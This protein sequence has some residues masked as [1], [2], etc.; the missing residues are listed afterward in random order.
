[1]ANRTQILKLEMLTQT[2]ALWEVYKK[3]E[4][5][6]ENFMKVVLACVE[7][8]KHYED[9][10]A[11]LVSLFFELK[12]WL[13][14]SIEFPSSETSSL[15]QLYRLLIRKN[16]VEAKEI[17]KI[18][19]TIIKVLILSF[20]DKNSKIALDLNTY[21]IELYETLALSADI[22]LKFFNAGYFEFNVHK[23][24]I[25]LCL[26]VSAS[27]S[28]S[29]Y[30]KFFDML[31]RAFTENRQKGLLEVLFLRQTIPQIASTLRGSVK[32]A[33]KTEDD[34]RE[35]LLAQVLKILVIFIQDFKRILNL[36]VL[37]LTSICKF[38]I[39]SGF[40]E[41]PRFVSAV[42]DAM[43]SRIS[44]TDPQDQLNLQ[45][46]LHSLS[47]LLI[48]GL[49]EK[50]FKYYFPFLKGFVWNSLHMCKNFSAEVKK[51]VLNSPSAAQKLQV[52]DVISPLFNCS[53]S[54]IELKL[55]LKFASISG[56]N[57]S[58]ILGLIYQS[59][60]LS[61]DPVSYF[62]CNGERFLK[63][64]LN[65]DFGPSKEMTLLTRFYLDSIEKTEKVFI[66]HVNKDVKLTL[67]VTKLSVSMEMMKKSRKILFD[68]RMQVKE[69]QWNT[70]AISFNMK[71]K[72][73]KKKYRI[74]LMINHKRQEILNEVIK[75]FK[76]LNSLEI[77]LKGKVEYFKFYSSDLNLLSIENPD[78]FSTLQ[79]M[80]FEKAS[81]YM[82]SNFFQLTTTNSKENYPNQTVY[83]EYQQNLVQNFSI[84]DSIWSIGGLKRLI[85]LLAASEKSEDFIIFF[86]I[87]TKACSCKNFRLV[88]DDEFFSVLRLV[89]V[90][91]AEFMHVGWLEAVEDFLNVAKH[92]DIYWCAF[93]N[94]F[95]CSEIWKNLSCDF[96]IYYVETIK[97]YIFNT[98]LL[99]KP[100][101]KERINGFF[102][103]LFEFCDKTCK[104]LVESYFIQIFPECEVPK[105]IEVQLLE[106]KSS[107][108]LALLKKLVN[109]HNQIF[110]NQWKVEG[111]YHLKS[112]FD[113][114]GRR[115]YLKRKLCTAP[116]SETHENFLRRTGLFSKIFQ[117]EESI[118]SD[119]I[120]DSAT[121]LSDYSTEQPQSVEEYQIEAE[122]NFTDYDIQATGWECEIIKIK[123]FLYG[124]LNISDECIEFC[125]KST[126]KPNMDIITYSDNNEKII[127]SSALNDTQILKD[128]VKIWPINMIKHIIVRK[129]VHIYSAVEIFFTT[130]KSVFIN[131]FTYKSLKTIYKKLKSFEKTGVV[132]L[133]MRDIERYTQK[134][135]AGEISNLEY[136]L[137]LNNYASRSF[138]DT[139]QYPIFP[140]IIK[141]FNS[142]KLDLSNKDTFRDLKY[143]VCA[144]TLESQRSAKKHFFLT[145]SD[146]CPYNFGS[147]YS[148]S[149]IVLHYAIRLEPFASDNKKLHRGKYDVPDRIFC[150]IKKA[151]NNSQNNS[152][153]TKELI[154]EFYYLP[155]LFVNINHE[156]FGTTQT[157]VEVNDAKLPKWA[158][159]NAFTFVYKHRKALESGF[160]SRNLHS[161]IDLIFGY[162]QNS[163]PGEAAFNIFHPI[164]YEDKYAKM[165]LEESEDY[166]KAYFCQALHFGQTPRQIFKVPHPKRDSATDKVQIYER[167]T[168]QYRYECSKKFVYHKPIFILS[169]QSSFIVIFVQEKVI[170]AI[171][172]W[173]NTGSYDTS[174]GK[175][176]ELVG[177]FYTETF[178]ADL[179]QDDLII[180]SGQSDLCIYMHNMSGKIYKVL[181]FHTMPI[182]SLS[183]GSCVL[184]ASLD[185]T[186]VVWTEHNK[187]LLLGHTS[188]ITSAKLMN[189]F[190]LIIS[191]SDFI[192]IHD[193][194]TGEVIRKIDE[195]SSKVLVNDYGMIFI[196]CE[197]EIKIYYMTGQVFK[198]IAVKKI[199]K[200][201][202]VINECLIVEDSSCLRFIQVYDMVESC[203]YLQEPME[204][205]QMYYCR[206][207]DLIFLVNHNDMHT[208]YS[209]DVSSTEK[210][211]LWH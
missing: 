189:E 26:W 142:S 99:K 65:Y 167:I 124:T 152:S 113:S 194:R 55:A 180:S 72:V 33:K 24:T 123:G 8:L 114:F 34:P 138:H 35:M 22:R 154:P 116:T 56:E 30:S 165:L 209:L 60:G 74:V 137:I 3:K 119:I 47:I 160:V 97:T 143:P 37:K 43:Y 199:T 92:L 170:M 17:D 208:L 69:K 134:W 89:M 122:V 129:Y 6:I 28:L 63:V 67:N 205:S 59:Q 162:K 173:S 102:L 195:K 96:M 40:S 127:C 135:K 149:G 108:S 9:Q 98:D 88:V 187:M 111:L 150:S 94:I 38:I 50:L 86:H 178:K 176:V 32:I 166:H 49:E 19:D 161:W 16:T 207:K 103:E 101:E 139:S 159:N 125:S 130:G 198:R 93:D 181:R 201:F 39:K 164:T 168:E 156:N 115:V 117:A 78:N 179:Y 10:E 136:L 120:E 64:P 126:P 112:S 31:I 188:E 23:I 106:K 100:K 4:Y 61:N 211:E 44:L 57:A 131:F 186:I 157:G 192:L 110:V 12:H 206:N 48:P 183:G 70:M 83:L 190:C 87:L 133:K 77:C 107:K 41:A 128:T 18:S 155:E 79:K 5:S 15:L 62:L 169:T 82:N 158:N 132:F 204:L 95:L 54:V 66:L 25:S 46:I 36:Q 85:P 146:G 144:Q 29:V 177:L 145:A 11:S 76:T 73:A 140:W 153:D 104:D 42:L 80:D 193:Y 175:E 105:S 141:D 81:L 13:E 84:F 147:H 90:K 185:S 75:D 53:F 14:K 2:H 148:S 163:R 71:Q 171:Y 51:M 196:R 174:N 182:T 210:F 20:D 109:E 118:N 7:E 121:N 1:M 191:C 52:V 27:N 58:K 197:D 200:N 184:S 172:K 21:Y 202:H 151:W 45:L 68:V 203:I 91:K